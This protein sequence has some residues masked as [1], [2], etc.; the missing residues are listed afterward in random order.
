MVGS[1]TCVSFCPAIFFRRVLKHCSK[2]PKI[3]KNKR[4]GVKKNEILGPVAG[5]QGHTAPQTKGFARYSENGGSLK[6]FV[7]VAV[8]HLQ[9]PVG[10]GCIVA[11]LHDF[12]C[13]FILFDV[14]K[15]NGI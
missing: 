9:D 13:A 5:N 11:F 2:T 8:D 10:G 6:T 12:F 7:F 15:K 4:L 1:A 3:T 14:A